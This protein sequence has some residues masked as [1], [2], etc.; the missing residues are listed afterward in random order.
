L[1]PLALSP[2]LFQGFEDFEGFN[3]CGVQMPAAFNASRS[4]ACGVQGFAFNMLKFLVSGLN[5][6]GF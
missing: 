1:S 4:I 5:S 2:C 6:F 3:A